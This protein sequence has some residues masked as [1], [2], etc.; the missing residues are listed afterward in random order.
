M[1]IRLTWPEVKDLI[2]KHAE[3]PGVQLGEPRIYIST[4]YGQEMEY[5]EKDVSIEFP[6]VPKQPEAPQTPELIQTENDVPF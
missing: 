4:P 2:V 3:L 6:I 5:E 1:T